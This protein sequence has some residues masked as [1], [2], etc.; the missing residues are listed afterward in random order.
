MPYA[1]I[2]FRIKP[3]HEKELEEVFGNAPQLESPIIV[4]DQGRQTGRLLGT[5]VFVKDDVLVRLVHYEGDFKGIAQHLA[6]QRHVHTIEHQIVPYLAETRDTRTPQGFA[7]FFRNATMRC[8]T[9]SSSET[10]T[11]GV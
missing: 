9:Q 7:E 1:M 6:A 2:T 11:S 4:D 8:I 10:H 5:G 3:G